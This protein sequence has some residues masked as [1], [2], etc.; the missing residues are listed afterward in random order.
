M[1]PGRVLL[2]PTGIDGP[3]HGRSEAV[4]AHH[5][6]SAFGRRRASVG[7]TL[8]PHHP[9]VVPHDVLDREAVPELGTG[10]DRLLDE[11]GVED[12]SAWAECLGNAVRGGR[13]PR[14]LDAF[15]VECD[16]CHR[17]APRGLHAVQQAPCLQVRHPA[18]MEVMGGH[19]VAGEPGPVHQQHVEAS[20]GK[21]HRHRGSGASCPHYDGVVH[22]TSMTAAG[23]AFNAGRRRPRNTARSW[24]S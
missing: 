22:E 24:L 9:A 3:G 17:R 1:G 7:T 20:S 4:G 16:L 19:R 23:T 15:D 2:V 6:P 12:G 8:D 18:L 10:L 13:T 14:D 21:E 11:D 5:E